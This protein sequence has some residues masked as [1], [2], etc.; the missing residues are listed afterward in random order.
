MP[1]QQWSLFFVYF[2]SLFF[3]LFFLL[4]PIILFC[5]ISLIYHH[6]I[7]RHF[8]YL[9]SKQSEKILTDKTMLV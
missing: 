5:K 1:S 3:K 4:Q 6:N 8:I 2:W 7:L 9:N